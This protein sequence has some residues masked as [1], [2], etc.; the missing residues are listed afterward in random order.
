MKETF[1]KSLAYILAMIMI[2]ALLPGTAL[3]ENVNTGVTGLT[4]ESSGDGS[5]ANNGG[6]ITGS[7]KAS[8]SSGCSGTTYTAQT[9]TVT[10]TN[11]SDA[12]ALLSFDYS[13]TLSGG[14]ATVDGAAVTAGAAFSKKL[15]V[16]ETVEVSITS[17]GAEGTTSIEITNLK[18]TEEKPVNITFKTPTNGSYTVNGETISADTTKTV[19]STESV[20]LAATPVSGYKFFGWYN[21]TT[22]SYFAT[23]QSATTSFTDDQAVVPQFVSSTTP[24]FKV[25]SMLYTDLNE[26]ISYAQSSGNAKIALISDGTL[27]AGDYT[28]P[29]GKTLLIPFD[30]AQTVYT[31]TPEVVYSSHVNPSTFRTLTM[32]NGAKI[33]VANGGALCVPSKLCAYGTGSGSWNG[34]PPES[35]DVSPWMKAVPLTYSPAVSSMSTATSPAPATYMPAQAQRS[36]SASRF[37]AGEEAPQPQVWRVTRRRYSQLT[38]IMCRTSKFRSPIIPVQ[39]RRYIRLSICRARLLLPPRHL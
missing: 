18:L 5:W 9:G 23:S 26:A 3:A 22:G 14:S 11:S 35:T 21:D 13:L 27:P 38:S 15:E 4:A 29:S 7:V 34:T 10:F 8:S 36:G 31:T 16:G 6:T 28:I 39:Q 32:A 24:V 19:L 30:D 2:I 37:D 1:K 20:T 25:G 33:T 17:P 12:V